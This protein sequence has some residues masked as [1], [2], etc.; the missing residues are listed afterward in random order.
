V[1]PVFL[2]TA[3]GTI[4]NV[5]STRLGRIVDRSR[6]LADR[7]RTA[8]VPLPAIE[9]ELALL[10]RRRRLAN[11]AIGCG[12]GSALLVCVL[13]ASAF[14]GYF[15]HWNVSG[16]LAFLFVAAMAFVVGAL[17][18]FLREVLLAA[19]TARIERR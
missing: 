1:A 16:P 15:F 8:G 18:V 10:Q 12:T 14:V 19:E 4:L 7:E 5:L 9:G 17:V 13:I 11:L 3:I 6:V 2:L